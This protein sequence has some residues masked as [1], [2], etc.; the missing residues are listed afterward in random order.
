MLDAPNGALKHCSTGGTRLIDLDTP[1][2]RDAAHAPQLGQLRTDV[3][4]PKRGP[5]VLPVPTLEWIPRKHLRPS[6][7]LPGPVRGPR[8][9]QAQQ[10]ARE[11]KQASQLLHR[12][13]S[14]PD[15]SQEATAVKPV[16]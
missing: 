10:S 6:L 9:P 3:A 11:H 15:V 7:L 8:V 5:E 1:R 4:V 16:V 14:F 12:L 13:T 2:T